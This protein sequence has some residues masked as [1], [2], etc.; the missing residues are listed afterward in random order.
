MSQTAVFQTLKVV[1]KDAITFTLSPTRVAYANSLVRTIKSHV[2]TV[3]FRADMNEVGATTDVTVYKNTTPMSNEMLADRIGLLL[4]HNDSPESW[5]KERFLFKLHVKNTTSA[6]RHVTASD[7]EVL[8]KQDGAEEERVKVPNTQFFHPD[9]VSQQ[10]CLI[11]TLKPQVEG[12]DPEE[13][14]LEAWATAGVGREHVRF[15]PTC[16]CAYGYT[17]DE[18]ATRIQ[19]QWI[20]WLKEYK[21]VDPKELEK[22]ADLKK[23]LELEFRSMQIW[24]CYKEDGDGEPYSFDWTVE[25]AGPLSPQQCVYRGCLAMAALCDKYANIDTGDLPSNVRIQPADAKVKGFDILFEGED[26]TLGNALQTWID[27]TYI[28]TGAGGI[29]YAGFKVP[30]PLRDEGLLR[31][32]VEELDEGVAR[33]AIAAACSAMAEQYR[34]WAAEWS[35]VTGSPTT[36]LQTKA[37]V[38]ARMEEGKE[39]GLVWDAHARGS[40]AAAPGTVASPAQEP[41]LKSILKRGTSVKPV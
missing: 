5:E 10:T 30:H 20:R 25:S 26:Y 6:I 4:V 32:G 36:L 9:P 37:P 18:S 1:S 13:I 28:S 21:K 8:E 38:V 35:K 7:F 23:S 31:L 17:R 24:R 33:Q 19:E 12:Q 34:N 14:H 29:H 2:P 22:E 39:P 15:Q 11:A 41:Q 40:S 3:A 16:I 27:D